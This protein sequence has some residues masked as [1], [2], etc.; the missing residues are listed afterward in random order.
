MGRADIRLRICVGATVLGFAVALMTA[1]GCTSLRFAEGSTPFPS[2]TPV[3]TDDAGKALVDLP[4]SSEPLRLIVFDFPWCPPCS[5]AWEAVGTVSKTVPGGN[6]RI[7]R[8]LFDREKFDTARGT[9]ETAPL[10]PAPPP[11]PVAFPVTT[12]TALPAQF[13]ERYK[14]EQAPMLLLS[15]GSGKILKRWVGYTPGLA[16]SLRGEIARRLK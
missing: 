16:D 9:A 11:P 6:V 2:K 10:R 12:V 13:R 1:G 8:V 7:Y 4:P 14:M 3:M 5:D 15:D